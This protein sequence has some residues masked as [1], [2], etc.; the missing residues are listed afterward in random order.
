MPAGAARSAGVLEATVDAMEAAGA[1]RGAIRAVIG[2]TI[3]QRAYEVGPE[4]FETFLAE[5]AG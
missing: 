4:F 3:S 1:R 5:D 2:P